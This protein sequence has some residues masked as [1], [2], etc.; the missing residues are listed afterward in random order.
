MKNAMRLLEA[1]GRIPDEYILDAHADVPK[2]SLSFKRIAL[3]AA[4]AAAL[5]LLAGCAA[6]AWHWYAT[7]FSM[8]RQE[9]LSDSQV[10]YIQENAQD[11][12]ESQALDGYTMELTSTLAENQRAF[13]TLKFTAPEDVDLVNRAEGEQLHFGSVY[14]VSEGSDQPIGLACHIVEDGDGRDNTANLVLSMGPTDISGKEIQ[15]GSDQHWHI[16]LENLLVECWDREYEEEL[17]RTK[18]ADMTDYMFTDE[19]AAR[20]HSQESLLSGKW[21]FDV[22]FPN[23]DNACLEFLTE[24]MVTK[25][26]VTRRERMDSIFY[27]TQEAVE[28]ITV[29]SIRLRVFSAEVAFV[30]PAAIEGSDFPDFFCACLDMG[31]AYNPLTKLS[32]EDENFFVVLKDGTR[33]DF[34]QDEGARDCAYLKTD[35]PIVLEDVDYLQLS[36]GTK[37][38]PVSNG[39]Q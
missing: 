8:Q 17:I 26:V 19:E 36:D 3:I 22:T 13:V 37:L 24:P 9:P 21:E 39:G 7:Y 29:T 30:E 28:D 27:D 1:I 11:V 10:S 32:R 4:A 14:A 2:S 20:S 38:Y 5:L 16:V 31:D 12:H 15:L 18:Y 25:A 33:I 6:Y 23:A 35:S 34:W